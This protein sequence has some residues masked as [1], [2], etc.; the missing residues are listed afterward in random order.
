MR[1]QTDSESAANR[2]MRP[3][4][5]GLLLVAAA[6][7]GGCYDAASL[8]EKAKQEQSSTRLEEVALGIYRT[9]LPR[10]DDDMSTVTLELDFFGN[11]A[12]KDVPDAT[13]NLEEANYLLRHQILVAVRQSTADEFADPQLQ[14]VRDRVLG[15]ANGLLPDAPIQSIGIKDMSYLE[16]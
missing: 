3:A 5:T 11:I 4:A 1:R 15:V 12:K 10:N 14:A 2:S 6:A 13:T 7:T 9:T 8:I 16:D